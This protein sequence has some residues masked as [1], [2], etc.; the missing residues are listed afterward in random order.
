MKKKTS[1]PDPL[2]EA[3]DNFW[4]KRRIYRKKIGDARAVLFPLVKAL[5]PV[6][7][8]AKDHPAVPLLL[9]GDEMEHISWDF[10]FNQTQYLPQLK[11]QMKKFTEATLVKYLSDLVATDAV[12]I[13]NGSPGNGCFAAAEAVSKARWV[14]L[15]ARAAVHVVSPTSTAGALAGIRLIQETCH[16]SMYDPGSHG[17]GLLGASYTHGVVKRCLQYLTPRVRRS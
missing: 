11:K 10:R 17:N 14:Y 13:S 12:A 15:S 4:A 5:A 7:P 6:D 16:G 1:K 3:I 9:V 8:K 2:I